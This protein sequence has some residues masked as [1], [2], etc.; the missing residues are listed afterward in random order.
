MLSAVGRITRA[1]VPER[2]EIKDLRCNMKIASRTLARP[3]PNRSMISRSEGSL[4]PTLSR[5]EN[6][7]NSIQSAI[8][9]YFLRAGMVALCLSSWVGSS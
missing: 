5:P 9:S 1:V 7:C 6:T 2:A 3:A 8:S 4:S